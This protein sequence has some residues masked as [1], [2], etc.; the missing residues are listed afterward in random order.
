MSTISRNA[1]TYADTLYK[2]LPT[3]IAALG[4]QAS[5]RYVEFFAAN[6]RNPHTRRVYA[7]ACSRF[8]GPGSTTRSDHYSFEVRNHPDSFAELARHYRVIKRSWM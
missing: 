1:H 4:N 3:V 2:V 8:L 7:R 5:W 6:I